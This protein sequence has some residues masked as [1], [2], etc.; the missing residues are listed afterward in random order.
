MTKTYNF[1]LVKM[2]CI[3]FFDIAL[4]IHSVNSILNSR[5]V[6]TFDLIH[7]SFVLPR[8]ISHFTKVLFLCFRT[9]GG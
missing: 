5:A 3:I 1:N 2:N 7:L 6:S 8:I 9:L 4:H